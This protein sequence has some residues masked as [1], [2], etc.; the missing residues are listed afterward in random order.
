M[1]YQKYMYFAKIARKNGDE[2]IAQLFES[3]AKHETAHAEG[4]LRNLYPMAKLTTEDC[5]RIAMEGEFFEYSEMYPQYAKA[6]QEEGA[7]EWM[8]KEF[9]DGIEECKD[10]SSMFKATLDEQKLKKLSKV[11]KG[12]TRV[13]KEHYENYKRAYE[14]SGSGVFTESDQ[15]LDSEEK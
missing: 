5:L 6:A 7:E 15:Y 12:L 11:F 10:H 4:H 3:T 14:K 1:A 9:Q 8:I 2:E 13:E